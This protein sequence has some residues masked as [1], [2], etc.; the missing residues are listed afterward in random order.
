MSALEIRQVREKG[1]KQNEGINCHE[2]QERGSL[3]KKT[4]DIKGTGKPVI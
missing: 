1:M 3:N 2:F 4:N